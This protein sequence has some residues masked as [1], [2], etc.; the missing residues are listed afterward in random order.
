MGKNR[1]S[2]EQSTSAYRL[3]ANKRSNKEPLQRNV[4]FRQAPGNFEQGRRTSGQQG[5]TKMSN[6]RSD[7]GRR[8]LK[9]IVSVGQKSST[10]KVVEQGLSK[11]VEQ[12]RRTRLNKRGSN[13]VSDKDV[14]QGRTRSNKESSFNE[15][16]YI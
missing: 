15:L 9:Q 13:K 11:D 8:R 12:V 16:Q 14:A 10:N 6:K 3:E 5:R 4:H 7:K 2:V 1:T